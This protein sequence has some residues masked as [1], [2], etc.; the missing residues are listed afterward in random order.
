MEKGTKKKTPKALR[1]LVLALILM[2]GVG[3][4]LWVQ[5]LAFETTDDAQIDGN[6]IPIRASV[7]AYLDHIYFK[8]NQKVRKGDTLFTF[9]TVVLN[10]KVQQAIAALRNAEAQLGVTD[11]KE[12][13]SIQSADASLKTSISNE[14]TI[15]ATQARLTKAQ[16]DFDR[17]KALLQIKAL[18][19]EQYE[20][21]KTELQQAQADYKKAVSLQQSSVITSLGLKSQAKA[22]HKQILAIQALIKEK[23]ANLQLAQEELS[24]AY[25][26]APSSGIVTK[27][28]VELGQYVLTG[29]ALCAI[30]DNQ[31]LWVTANVKETQLDNI[32][33]GQEVIIHVD[34]YP[35]MKLKGKVVSGGG[36]TGARFSLIPPDNA[37]GNFIKIVQRF[38][39]RIAL[40]D[41]PKEKSDL[42]FQGLSAFVKIKTQ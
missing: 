35:G 2:F 37:T 1:I 12:R 6:I 11:S 19:Q 41:V 28:S 5:S 10:A 9:N 38:P 15:A 17:A 34:A 30:V 32:R 20:T 24:H 14:Q 7:T 29:Q 26:L 25:V 18:T 27:R 31:H 13:A 3:V 23:E 8:D 21:A 36:A 40:I 4:F 39:L 16:S 33:S 22:A 42:L